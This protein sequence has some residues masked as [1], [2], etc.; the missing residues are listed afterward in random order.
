M[1]GIAVGAGSV[2]VGLAVDSWGGSSNVAGKFWLH[3]LTM[4]AS[5]RKIGTTDFIPPRL[6]PIPPAADLAHRIRG[7]L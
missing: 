4:K 7:F 2:M 5:A 3:P 6:Y 1:A